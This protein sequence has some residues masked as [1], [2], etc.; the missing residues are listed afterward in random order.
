MGLVNLKCSSCGATLTFDDSL[1][2]GF[3]Q[4]CGAAFVLQDE[5][6]N[7]YTTNVNNID[8]A[9]VYNNSFENDIRELRELVK[10]KNLTGAKEKADIIYNQYNNCFE[11]KVVLNNSIDNCCKFMESS[12]LS[13]DYMR[14][15]VENICVPAAKI[16]I[17]EIWKCAASDYKV[18]SDRVCELN[19]YF[20]ALT[21]V[22]AN[23]DKGLTSSILQT[24]LNS[25][26]VKMDKILATFKDL[27]NKT[28]DEL[29]RMELKELYDSSNKQFSV[30]LTMSALLIASTLDN[31]IN[32]RIKRYDEL[33]NFEKIINK[34]LNDKKSK[35]KKKKTP[36]L[37]ILI[38]PA[39]LIVLGIILPMGPLTAVFILVAVGFVALVIILMDKV[40]KNIENIDKNRK[41]RV[42]FIIKDVDTSSY[43]TILKYSN[44]ICSK[45]EKNR[46]KA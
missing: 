7:F 20:D 35:E 30:G 16:E 43:S 41:C 4:Y 19:P 45:Y 17:E 15:Y 6:N 26:Y 24:I 8:N 12:G 14:Y 42:A 33:P 32:L 3:C 1:K 21:K 29:N 46:K 13:W 18:A 36:I 10:A 38:V 44:E 28:V 23:N 39:V 40:N 31:D 9:V 11:A 5:T 27:N 37:L 2:K 25:I 22:V 34:E